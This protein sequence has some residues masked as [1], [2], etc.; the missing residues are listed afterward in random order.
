MMKGV[1]CP[2][3]T[4]IVQADTLYET[5]LPFGIDEVSEEELGNVHK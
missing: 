3:R 4:E 1:N 5:S 2:L